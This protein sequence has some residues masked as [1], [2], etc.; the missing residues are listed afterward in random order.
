MFVFIFGGSASGKSEYAEKRAAELAASEG[1]RLIYLAAMKP[2]GEEAQRRIARH[3][4]MRSGRGF[5]TVERYTD[6][7]G[8]ARQQARLLQG[9][10]LLLE[11]MSNLT[12][13]EL[14]D[15][16]GAGA[17]AAGAILDGIS[18]LRSI[19][20]S[21]IV[22]S[23]DVFGGGRRYDAGTDSFISTLGE[24]NRTLALQADEAVEVVYSLPVFLK[25]KESDGWRH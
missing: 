17:D 11:C 20:S 16:E 15:E 3:R 24:V 12:A 2:F 9:S 8:L 7:A 19:C 21:L 6:L 22:V 4:R 13:N 10:C 14:F 23:L 1:S 25:R 5:I 18:C